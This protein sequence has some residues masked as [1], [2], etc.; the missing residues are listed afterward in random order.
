M[1]DGYY[2]I[3]EEEIWMCI[4]IVPLLLIILGCVGTI[5]ISTEPCPYAW[6]ML[7]LSMGLILKVIFKAERKKEK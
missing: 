6:T 5:E 7:L 4:K 1:N 3:T 2:S